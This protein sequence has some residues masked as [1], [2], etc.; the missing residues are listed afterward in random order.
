MQAYRTKLELR[1][2]ELR[3]ARVEIKESQS[4]C[5]DL[6]DAAPVGYFTLTPARRISEVNLTGARLLGIDRNRLINR[7]FSEFVAPEF[8]AVLR[9]HCKNVLSKGERE[10]CELRLIRKDGKSFYASLD[11]IATGI[12]RIRCA[13]S[14]ITEQKQAELNSQ[15]LTRLNERMRGI[16]EPEELLR[17]VA[18]SVGGYLS[19][20]RCFFNQILIEHNQAF[21]YRDYHKGVPSFAGRASLSLFSPGTVSE[22]KAGRTVVNRDSKK[23]PHRAARCEGGDRSHGFRAYVAVPLLRDGRWTSTLWVSAN[24][25]RTWSKQEVTLL[26]TVAERTWS[27]F[28]KVTLNAALRESEQRLKLAIEN[29]G[30]GTWDVDLQTAKAIWSENHFRLLG[31]EPHPNGEAS[32]DMGWSRIHPD[33]LESVRREFDRAKQKHDLYSPDYRILKP[34]SNEVIWLSAFGRF[35]YNET[36]DAVRFIGIFFNSTD[37]RRMEEEIRRSRDELEIRVKERTEE[38]AETVHRLSIEAEERKRTEK[39]LSKMARD[40]EKRAKEIN[41]LYSISY[42]LDKQYLRLE[43]KLQNIVN[44][45][46]SGWQYPEITCARVLLEGK[47]YRSDHFE[48][49]PWRQSTEITVKGEAVGL[50]EVFYL[51]E[52]PD[53]E[54]GPFSKDERG[55][56]TAI[57]VELEEIVEHMRLDAGLRKAHELLESMFSTIDVMIAYMDKD[58]NFIRVNRAYAEIDGKTPEYFSGRNHFS[59]FPNEE[60]EAIFRKVVET[61]TPYFTYSKP[62]IYA[63]HPDRAAD[64]EVTYWDWG[65]QPVRESDGIVGG[66]VLS[67]INVTERVQSQAALRTASWYARSLIEASLDPLVTISA[68]GKIMDINEATELVTGVPRKDLIGSDFS[69]YFTDPEKARAGYEQVFSTG[70]VRDYPL[71]I[72][73]T[74]GRI[75]DVL[76]NSSLFKNEAGEVRGVFASAR[77]VTEIKEIQKR[78]EGT[79]LLLDLFVKKRTRRDYLDSVTELVH[80]WS[81]CRCVGIRVV[82]DRE[83]IPYESFVGFSQEFWES[84]HWLSIR[85]D[86]CACIRVITGLPDPQDHPLMTAEGSFRCDNTFDFLGRL[87]EEER[88]RFRGICIR[89]GFRS[90]AIIPLRYS[91]RILGAIHLADEREGTVP[92]RTV[93]FIESMAPLIGE[94]INRFNLEEAVR[95]SEGRLRLLSSQLLSI[96]EAERRR[97]AREIHDSLGQSLSAIKFRMEGITIRKKKAEVL[98]GLKTIIPII[99]QAVEETRRIQMDLRPSVLDDLGILA[100]MNWFC[101]EFQK[102]YPGIEI[103]RNIGL[104]EGE[105]PE[106]LKTVIYR[107]S[108]EALNNV[109]KHSKADRVMYS[110]ERNGN[111]IGLTIHDNGRGM[112]L[113]EQ[114]HSPKHSDHGMGLESMRERAQ[115]SGGSFRID[116]GEG[117]GTIIRVNWSI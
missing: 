89:N 57:A 85:E 45:V 106:S 59:L 62:F 21:I 75:V 87:S 70:S 22:M 115:L 56:I 49:T 101:R 71:A 104:Q 16:D 31:Y 14:D 35:V 79:N 5:V 69:D 47:E 39:V 17:A 44:I 27:A 74:S 94:S 117:K 105:I 114:T 38:L 11:C 92:M 77:D 111:E 19:V 81:D 63:E 55:L 48:E 4:K 95:E 112:D 20:S 103:K 37:R 10:R 107:I 53:L 67:L 80:R 36:G 50:V 28:E 40:L 46:P 51:E 97:V 33:D 83:Y 100:T 99:Q 78:I 12:S 29:A 91:D 66:I 2:E 23:D 18:E 1:Q 54:E 26:E 82:N 86:Q 109:A 90:V 60:N 7:T 73:H 113:E 34:G 84:E 15:F 68:D 52:R 96:Q 3:R 98:D 13:V 43:E 42:Y 64:R 76:Y 9:G 61:G 41:C 6:F 88:R 25:P 110:L 24:K 30:I 93:E 58:F 102:T 116:S 72:R 32:F 65:V 8:R 108:Q